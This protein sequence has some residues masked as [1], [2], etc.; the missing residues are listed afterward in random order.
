MADTSIYKI[1]EQMLKEYGVHDY[2][3]DVEIHSVDPSNVKY[4]YPNGDLFLSANAFSDNPLNGKI[5]AA[6][7]ALRIDA[8]TMLSSLFKHKIFKTVMRIQNL[9]TTED[10]NVEFLRITPVS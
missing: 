6:D 3:I 8:K 9:D 1:A 7:N 10:L 2:D 4:I 5:V